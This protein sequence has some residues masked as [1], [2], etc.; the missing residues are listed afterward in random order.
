MTNLQYR[1]FCVEI[2]NR[3]VRLRVS[4]FFFSSR[5]RHTILT[6]D[7]SSDVC[8]SDLRSG[9]AIPAAFSNSG[10]SW[11]ADRIERGV[12]TSNQPQHVIETGVWSLPFGKDG[13][14]G[15]NAWGRAFAGGFKFSEI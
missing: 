4:I 2:E 9:Y 13:I 10:K 1:R 5:R 11:A 3:C 6:C 12:S 7:W 14:G 15:G 8:S